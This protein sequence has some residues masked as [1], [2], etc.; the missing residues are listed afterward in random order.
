MQK[1]TQT[2]LSRDARYIAAAVQGIVAWE[3]LV[4][5][6][7]KVLSGTFPPGLA[8]I[9]SDGVKNNPNGWYVSF[10]QQFVLPHSVAFGYAIE[11][12]EIL[13]GVALLAGAMFLLGPARH[14][15]DPQYRLAVSEVVAA[16]AASLAC[17][18]LCINFHFFMGDGFIP[19]INTANAFDQGIS[20]DTLMPP[21]SILIL[22]VNI[23]VLGDMIGRPIPQLFRSI[24]NRERSFLSG[25]QKIATGAAD[26]PSH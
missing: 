21:I 18:F 19:G 14:Q 3:W 5:G 10:L 24:V 15:G 8:S 2:M 6:T 20:L 17:T 16:A 26:T 9:L 11:F 25:R 22:C 12:T 1:E 4:S 23:Y 7:N 13:I